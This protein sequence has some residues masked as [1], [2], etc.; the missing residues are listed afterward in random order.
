MATPTTLA[1]DPAYPEATA[2]F[3]PRLQLTEPELHAWDVGGFHIHAEPL[4]TRAEVEEIRAACERVAQR[5]YATGI[6]P[7]WRAWEP[8]AAPTALC[9]ID[10]GWYSDPVIR[11]AAASPRLGRVAAQLIGAHGIR[12]WHDQYLRKPRSGGGVVPYHQDWMYWQEIDRCRTVTCW[13]AL[14]D[15]SADMGP[16]VFLKGSHQSGLRLDLKPEHYTGETLDESP[17]G[18]EHAAVP[19]VVRAG[20]VSFH[21]GATMHGS[22][23]NRTPSDR[24]SLVSHVIASDCA[25]RKGVQEHPHMCIKDMA[26]FDDH[27]RHA[28]RFRGPQFP[29]MWRAS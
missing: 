2:E 16:M 26:R 5:D 21:H 12:L 10:N 28:E 19:V 24:V 15:V 18:R 14:A 23:V 27:P 4:F 11:A 1:C 20:Q 17:L 3:R 7:G 8:G 6:A 22:G 13:I 9:K 29:W 25:Y